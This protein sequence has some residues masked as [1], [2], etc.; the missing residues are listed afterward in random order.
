MSQEEVPL[1]CAACITM[2]LAENKSKRKKESVGKKVFRRK[3]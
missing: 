3:E 2:H 1:T